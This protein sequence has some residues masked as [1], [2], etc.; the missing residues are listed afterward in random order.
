MALA[1]CA[2]LACSHAAAQVGLATLELAGQP[3]TLVYP[4]AEKAARL[5]QGPLEIEVAVDAAP[6]PGPHRLVV[7]SHGTGGSALSDHGLAATLARAGFVVAQPRH[8]GDHHAD[9]S[10]AGPAA[11]ATRPRE[12]SAVIDALAASP[13][14]QPRLRLDQ[15]GVHGMS[16]G[17]GTAL[18]MAGARWRVLDLVRH[19][20][21]HGDEDEGFCYNGAT[22][23]DAR[24]QRKASFERGRSAPEAYLPAELTAWQG[25]RDD[26]DPRP[27]RRV[28]AV[29]A[30]VPVA[31]IFSPASLGA[32]RIP[33]A[34]VGAERDRNL[35]PAFHSQRV[36]ASC[37]ACVSLGDLRGAGHFDLLAPWPAELAQRVGATQARGGFPEPGFD[38]A[39]RQAAFDRIADF[40]DRTLGR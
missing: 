19:C 15:V 29:S 4:T 39:L 34:I 14:W 20:A 37:K 10:K 13:A 23:A 2:S 35:L 27:D 17:G 11:W 3:L 6:T 16:A 33:V 36:L 7:M 18:V 40:F 30:A 21:E 22:S 26:P 28:A 9:A 5:V 12:V 24:A 38:P 31:A 8:A 1:L 25:G 32:I